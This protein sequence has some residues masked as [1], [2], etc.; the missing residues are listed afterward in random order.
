MSACFFIALL[1]VAFPSIALAESGTK[2]R[3]PQHPSSDSTS[4]RVY[5]RPAQNGPNPYLPGSHPDYKL[6]VAASGYSVV[7]LRDQRKWVE[8]YAA[9]QTVF[10]GQLYWFTNEREKGIFAAAPVKY[11]P[12]L[13][14]DCIVSYSETTKRVAGDPRFG[15]VHRGRVYFFASAQKQ[16]RFQNNVDQYRNA[17]LAQN[18]N[19]IVCKI[20]QQKEIQGLSATVAM[21]GGVRYL[22]ASSHQ[23][24]LFGADPNRY[25][26][27]RMGTA[28]HIGSGSSPRLS[29]KQMRV[30]QGSSKKQSSMSTAESKGKQQDLASAKPLPNKSDS[31][32]KAAKSDE[33]APPKGILALEGYCPVSIQ[34]QGIWVEGKPN[35]YVKQAGKVYLFADEGQQKKFQES[36]Q[37]YLPALHGNCIVSLVAENKTISGSVFYSSS[38]TNPDR[39]ENKQQLY[40][41]AG[42][43]E[44]RAFEADPTT[45]IEAMQQ[46]TKPTQ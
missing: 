27:M 6:P 16:K 31:E 17:D 1:T 24:A 42:A 39:P 32:E 43:E 8:G 10:D 4:P 33:T 34:E 13:G 44:K 9:Y 21:Y 25:G 19:C 12:A 20:D 15:M 3:T 22:F 7:A 38:V 29:S 36:P 45:Y 2:Q 30:A 37:T 11:A 23:R 28:I 26:V 5:G 18:G 41:F 40:L 46:K 14:G 35:I